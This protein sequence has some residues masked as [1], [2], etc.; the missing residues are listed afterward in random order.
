MHLFYHCF[1]ITSLCTDKTVE[2]RTYEQLR[3]EL[4]VVSALLKLGPNIQHAVNPVKVTEFSKKAQEVVDLLTH[5]HHYD[6]A[7]ELA[8]MWDLGV[9]D[10]VKGCCTACL[11]ILSNIAPETGDPN[12]YIKH[13]DIAGET[14]FVIVI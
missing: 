6:E 1:Q 12:E 7:I 3:G 9:D 10:I 13:N 4:K 14:L 11:K 5:F 2:V 8:T